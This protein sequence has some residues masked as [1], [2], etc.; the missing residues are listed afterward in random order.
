MILRIWNLTL[1]SL[2]CDRANPCEHCSQSKLTCIYPPA[3][4]SPAGAKHQ[5][6]VFSQFD[7]RSTISEQLSRASRAGSDQLPESSQ[8][9][10]QL[11]Q[12][13]Q[14]LERALSRASVAAPTPPQESEST[15]PCIR[16]FFNKNVFCGHS[17]WMHS[18]PP[19]VQIVNVQLRLESNPATAHYRLLQRCKDASRRIK[20][21]QK[22]VPP[23]T[24]HLGDYLPGRELTDRL[25]QSYLDTFEF[26]FPVL[27]IPTF[28]REYE[29]YWLD[30]Q[31]YNQGF[32]L[33][34]LLIAAIGTIFQP[35]DEA[36]YLRSSAMQWVHAAQSWLT[37]PIDKTRLTTLGLQKLCLLLLA[38][39]AHDIDGDVLDLSSGYLLR[40]AMQMGF[41][42]DAASQG[43]RKLPPWEIQLRR[44][45][46]STILEIIV[47]TS[48]DSGTVP[49]LSTKDYDCK[50]P[51]NMD[52]MDSDSDFHSA[53]KR[54]DQFTQTSLQLMLMRSL[55][56]RLEIATVLNDFHPDSMTYEKAMQLTQKLLSFCSQDSELLRTFRKS[57]SNLTDFHI[58]TVELLT[59]R[60][61]L[62]LNYRYAIK[63][64]TDHK[65]YYSRKICLD[66]ALVIL[67]RSPQDL[68]HLLS[69]LRVNGGGIFRWVPLQA[70]CFVADELIYQIDTCGSAFSKDLLQLGNRHGLRKHV[71]DYCDFTLVRL[72]TGHTNVRPNM[73]VCGIVAQVDAMLTG[74]S[75]ED[76]VEAAFTA[77]LTNCY[78]ILQEQ[79]GESPASSE[80]LEV[81]HDPTNAGAVSLP[82]DLMVCPVS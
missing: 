39:L 22:V 40:A 5:T 12:R 82:S 56:L 58:N 63:A 67:N 20:A 30:P 35:R 42:V 43:F 1:P 19:F 34:L 15:Q 68:D 71:E 74:A 14:D 57:S 60:S 29:D 11:V 48:M 47:Q 73:M 7:D 4:G 54:R 26:I 76:S 45:L 52:D 32:V 2:R 75:I 55:P 16:G 23:V 33:K 70:V 21:V 49:L 53:E 6:S 65:Y 18:I 79:L 41:H 77:S 78:E 44:K 27:H 9:V 8:T 46:W 25:V 38:R 37:T 17:H 3:Q 80:S 69:Q 50:A 24:A 51:M 36:S 59:H 61:L 10:E 62:A 81:Q 31:G 13:V 66:S 28:L 72:R 64:K